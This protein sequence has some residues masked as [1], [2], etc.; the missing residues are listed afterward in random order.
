M[1]EAEVSALPHNQCFEPTAHQRCWWVPSALRAPAAAQAQR[2]VSAP[3]VLGA[4]PS[5]ES[6]SS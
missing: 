5:D 3:S 1:S 6:A 4:V 2:Y